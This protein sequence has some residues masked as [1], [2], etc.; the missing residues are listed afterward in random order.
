[1][2]G[3]RGIAS[4]KSPGFTLVELAIAMIIIGLLLGGLLR[5]MELISNAR[6][7]ATV[8]E[9]KSIQSAVYGFRD[10]YGALPGDM[11]G[12]LGRIIGCTAGNFCADGNSNGQVGTA[13][14]CNASGAPD[15]NGPENT[16]F[17]KHL[18]AGNFITGVNPAA[19]PAAGLRF[20]VTH[21]RSA[22][23]GGWT[24]GMAPII[25]A[26]GPGDRDCGGNGVILMLSLVPNNVRDTSLVMEA[27]QAEAIDRTLDDG[28][29]NSGDVS[30][31]YAILAGCDNDATN[32]YQLAVAARQCVMFFELGL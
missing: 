32:T 20:G 2:R 31:E 24:A 9:F 28:R 26:P 13:I 3:Q 22:I 19:D 7:R 8:A 27:S 15:P 23:G 18:A 17:W 14:F 30:G 4:F 6:I 29:P 11:N 25:A 10:K 21:P 5:G 1:M 16:Q 12:A